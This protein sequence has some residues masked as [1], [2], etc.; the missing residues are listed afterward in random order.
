L[1]VPRPRLGAGHSQLRS[2][3]LDVSVSEAAPDRTREQLRMHSVEFRTAFGQFFM[4]LGY[5]FLCYLAAGCGLIALAA[6]GVSHAV[7]PDGAMNAAPVSKQPTQAKPE[8]AASSTTALP[9]T[10]ERTPIWIAPTAKYPV[11]ALNV[12]TADRSR[13]LARDGVS[14]SRDGRL[15][16]REV[17]F[18]PSDGMS[19]YAATR[20]Q[21]PFQQEL[22]YQEPMQFR[23][24]T[25]PR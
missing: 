20:V 5:V 1:A 13:K 15:R 19:S 6:F 17:S 18:S 9:E 23:E 24:K 25:E 11:S 7:A 12:N 16:D 4:K 3:P 14:G 2:R 21:P 10:P 22:R 8:R